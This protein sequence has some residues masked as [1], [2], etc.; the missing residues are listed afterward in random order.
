LSTAGTTAGVGAVPA[1]DDDAAALDASERGRLQ[2]RCRRGM[3]E[4]DL[5]IERFFARHG[6]TLTR[7]QA[8]GLQVLME[9]PDNDLLA[10]LLGRTQPEGELAAAEVRDVLGL[11]RPGR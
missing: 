8:R 3:L 10:L 7:S 6:A 9:L 1:H 11:L 5:L 4:N 2:W